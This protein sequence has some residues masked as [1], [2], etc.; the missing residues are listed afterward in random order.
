MLHKHETTVPS[1]ELLH[2]VHDKIQ[3]VKETNK[4]GKF[5]C[6]A[7]NCVPKPAC[8]QDS[9]SLPEAVFPMDFHR[10]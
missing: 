1:S 4:E 2:L 10:E 7:C 9:V 8:L 3:E 5:L 6:F